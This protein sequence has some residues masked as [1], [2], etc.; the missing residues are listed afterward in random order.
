MTEFV[1][2]V[3]HRCRH[4]RCRMKLPV[5]VSNLREA[6]C[7]RG[8]HSSFYLRRCLVCEGPLDRKNSTQKVCRKSKCRSAF[9]AGLDL[10]RP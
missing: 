3:R 7:T 2:E 4:Q 5:A 1:E 9:R 6:F 8:C 10:G